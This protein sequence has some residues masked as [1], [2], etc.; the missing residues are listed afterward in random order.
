V[1]HATTNPDDTWV[2]TPIWAIQPGMWITTPAINDDPLRWWPI[3]D[4]HEWA[5]LTHGRPSC[6]I[7]LTTADDNWFFSIDD[8]VAVLCSTLTPAPK[9]DPWGDHWA[10]EAKRLTHLLEVIDRVNTLVDSWE[11]QR[12]VTLLVRRALRHDPI[13][14]TREP[15]A[16]EA[17]WVILPPAELCEAVA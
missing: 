4:T 6:G 13:G 10:N 14:S 3:T 5:G 2:W 9:A 8:E 15:D 1:H 11:E 12:W 16:D 17:T 7:H